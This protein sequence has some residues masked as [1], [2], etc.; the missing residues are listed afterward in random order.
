MILPSILVIYKLLQLSMKIYKLL[1]PSMKIYIFTLQCYGSLLECT[2]Q[3]LI[4]RAMMSTIAYRV[5][6]DFSDFPDVSN[7]KLFEN[8]CQFSNVALF[9]SF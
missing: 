1:Q 5:Y 8:G 3:G 9:V 7:T 4:Y 6:I 2:Y